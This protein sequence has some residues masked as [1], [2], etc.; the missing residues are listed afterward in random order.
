[1]KPR[2]AC[3]FPGQGSY[4]P[5]LFHNLADHYPVIEATLATVD[6]VAAGLG[7]APVAPMLLDTGSPTLQELVD[8]DPP[9]LHLAIFAASVTGFRLLVEEGGTSPDVLLGHSFGEL[10]ALTAAGALSLED[11]AYLVAQRD[12]SLL[13]SGAPRGGLVAVDCGYR[14]ARALLDVLGEWRLGIAADNRPDQVVFSGPDEELARLHDIAEALG[15]TATRLRIPYPFHNRLML[16]AADDFG[17]RTA[18]VPRRVPRLPVYSSLLGRYVEDV[19]DVDRVITG[20]LVMPVRFL[21]AVRAV[22]ADGV[23]R[24]VEAGPKGV[25]VDLV[26]RIVPDAVT[27]APF[28]QR[29]DRRGLLSDIERLLAE[30][31]GERA[32]EQPRATAGNSWRTTRA[33]AARR[34]P[35]AERGRWAERSTAVRPAAVPVRRKTAQ[36][37]PAA[38]PVR[39]EP[40]P[41]EVDAERS[42]GTGL[43]RDAVFEAVRG[44]YADL[45]GYPPDA[46]EPDAD[47]EADLGVD[48]I[49]QTEA[50]A[51]ALEHF[52]LS[53]SGTTVRLTDHPTLAAIVDLLV[54]LGAGRA[55]AGTVA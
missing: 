33:E 44:V 41:V 5:G 36:V 9:A 43:D 22:H 52:D 11:G 30:P 12:E 24:F 49:K 54:D 27:L 14:R 35:A 32:P 46:L 15:L 21:D 25:L 4:L 28:R 37:R 13:G 18:D 20:H 10:T 55:P 53:T 26:D 48:S 23:R 16:D 45:L 6:D 1:M 29:A 31:D 19:A 38:A 39:R 17:E 50:F 42:S 7:R 8:H 47:L 51:R 3:L 40:V 34:R 2:N